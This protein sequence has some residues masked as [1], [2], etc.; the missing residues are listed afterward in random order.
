MG[1]Q[2]YMGMGSL[3]DSFD[4]P[5]G[6]G[7]VS[8]ETPHSNLA[9][10]YTPNYGATYSGLNSGIPPANGT[11]W[12]GLLMP[13]R[14]FQ[15][16]T[17]GSEHANSSFGFPSLNSTAF[18][19]GAN[20]TFSGLRPPTLN[21]TW[22][23]SQSTLPGHNPTSF[24]P[25]LSAAPVS[26]PTSVGGALTSQ[27]QSSSA[28]VHI[29]QS[30]AGV[31]TQSAPGSFSGTNHYSHAGPHRPPPNQS[32]R[33][34]VPALGHFG[35]DSRAFFNGQMQ[36]YPPSFV[37]NMIYSDPFF[38]RPLT[39]QEI[40]AN[41][42]IPKKLPIFSGKPTEWGNFIGFFYHT[43]KACRLDHIANSLRL[44]E[45]L[46]EDA[47]REVG[48]MLANPE[49]LP[50]ILDT[51]FFRFGRPEFIVTEVIDEIRSMEPLQEECRESFIRFATSVQRLNA[52][53]QGAGQTAQLCSPE[54]LQLLY[55]RMPL[56]LQNQW[57]EVI[58]VRGRVSVADLSEWLMRKAVGYTMMLKRPVLGQSSARLNVHV[59]A[60]EVKKKENSK[61]EKLK[62]DSNEQS[63]KTGAD[64]KCAYCSGSCKN[65]PTCEKFKRRSVD[66][67]WE[68]ARGR[69]LCFRCLEKGHPLRECKSGKPCEIGGCGKEHH[70]LLHYEKRKPKE[71]SKNDPK[72]GATIAVHQSNDNVFDSLYRIIP[73]VLYGPKGCV[74]TFAFLDDG[75][76]VTLLEDK[77]SEDLGLTGSR[78][79]LSLKWTDN[80]VKREPNSR[81]VS[82]EISGVGKFDSKFAIGDVR[83][84]QR[85]LLPEQTVDG[86]FIRSQ[87]PHLTSV[88]FEPYEKATPRI[89]IGL[90]HSFLSVPRELKEG[91]K[92]EPIAT[93]TRLGWVLQGGNSSNSYLMEV[94]E[95][96]SK[97][98][99]LNEVVQK[100][101]AHESLG[102]KIPE[103]LME[104]EEVVRSRKLLENGVK[105]LNTGFEAELLW[106][107]DSVELPN[108]YSNA[109][110]RL[111]GI[112]RRMRKD[113]R[114]KSA[115][116]EKIQYYIDQGFVRKLDPSEV[117]SE[118]PRRWFLP[119]F[120]VFNPNK[121][122]IRV[123]FD[124]AAVF[125]GHSLNSNLLVGP[126]FNNSLLKM[127]FK[128]RQGV[129][130]ISGD[131]K[132]MFLMVRV[133]TKDQPAQ[134][135]LWRDGD[136]SC[137]PQVYLVERLMFGETCA[138]AIAQFVRN[139]NAEHYEKQFPRAVQAI[140]NNHY[141]DDYLDS[142]DSSED[143][144]NIT[145]QVIQI[146]Q[147]ADFDI[148]NFI[149]NSPEVRKGLPQDA[150]H[151]EVLNLERSI[152]STE[153]VLGMGWLF[154]QDKFVFQLNFHRVKSD[155]LNGSRIPSKREVLSVLMSI[156]DPCGLLSNFTIRGKLI[157]QKT[158]GVGSDWDDPISSE[159]YED[160]KSWFA[161]VQKAKTLRIP[162]CYSPIA[163]SAQVELHTFVDAS[164]LAFAAVSY[165]RFSS[166]DKRIEVALV[167]AKTKV[168][169]K[170]VVSIPRLELQAAVLGS[171]WAQTVQ[172][173]HS[174]KI[175][176][177]VFWSDSLTVLN[178]IASNARKYKP[179]VAHRISE[180]LDGTNVNEWR[181][182]PTNENVADEATKVTNE[183]TLQENS[184][185]F[186][187]PS[188]LL[189][190]ESEWPENRQIVSPCSEELRSLHV[191]V[192]AKDKQL[193]DHSRFSN[194]WVLVR[195]I[196]LVVRGVR[197][198]LARVRNEAQFEGPYTAGELEVAEK[199]LFKQI[200]HEAYS[201]EIEAL[202]NGEEIPSN[203]PLF[204][205]SPY[206]EEGILR[207][208]GRIDASPYAS[209]DTKRPIILPKNHHV[210]VLLAL[211]YHRRFHHQVP[212]IV[213][214][215]LRKRFHISSVRVLVRSLKKHCGYC[216]V[217]GSKPN[218]PLMSPLPTQRLTPFVKPFLYTGVD[219]FGPY[220]VTIGRRSEERYGV[221]FTCLVMRAI[222]IEVANGTST[223]AFFL[224][225]RNFL[226]RRG[227]VAE[228]W[229]DNA[230]NFVGCDRVLN[231]SLK[232]YPANEEVAM[233][234]AKRKIAWHFITPAS[235]H[236]GGAWERLVGVVKNV[237][238]ILL[239]KR[240]LRPETLNSFLIEVE[241][242]VN[243]RPLTHVAVDR[244]TQDCL[245]PNHFLLGE[246]N[247]MLPPGRFDDSD[248]I[249]P[250][251]W[252]L[253]QM[254][255]DHFWRRWIEEYLPDLTRRTKW[256]KRAKPL[257]VGDLVFIIDSGEYRNTWKRG[258]IHSVKS[259]RDGQVRSAVVKL[260]N[261]RKLERP[262]TKLAA[263]DIEGGGQN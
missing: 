246:S 147:R 4:A 261:G 113:E 81:K 124:A 51:L 194:Y 129:V 184:R 28:G 160:W 75:S 103:R 126:D 23:P 90:R 57:A 43:T 155:I 98:R 141:M 145:R 18:N 173:G 254:L 102:V 167:G 149:S 186:R 218:P 138:P 21:I 136:S 140:Q 134:L 79:G 73:V 263:L 258:V 39:P 143:A 112:E 45:S 114:L 104:S 171:R 259:G 41:N 58:V 224:C 15:S 11:G 128:F 68:F 54:L 71:D 251:Q 164:E 165:F 212:N 99:E 154:D 208:A 179:F 217:A 76:G 168:A 115:Y 26:I 135:F 84:V 207:V 153:R 118:H 72:K 191:H 8:F 29:P 150:L 31:S 131:I 221:L 250:K 93:R 120:P 133:A 139:K 66:N 130:A 87:F 216:R 237:L 205:L 209:F 125:M 132:D 105:F 74:E 35:V 166:P 85:L 256:F 245:T 215:E 52:T 119:H 187:G 53:L 96:E 243:A 200:Q 174:L 227:R 195:T 255:A 101:F 111:E 158:F 62:G 249:G 117:P 14:S 211:S 2:N 183:P 42:S 203:S 192:E 159:L 202:K 201:C 244:D 235:P 56:S 226:N 49:N 9:P 94:C 32:I 228:I 161:T 24:P 231:R 197:N 7:D 19:A 64:K 204:K 188:F 20:R 148:R 34:P 25:P 70:A 238:H 219:L 151:G 38:W 260:A 177:R 169:P 253:S 33:H 83:T 40:L 176:R 225:L 170:K 210:T 60:K 242:I 91:L 230:T 181:W 223:E 152:E 80:V 127:I 178:W 189:N 108:N 36:N 12:S 163:T 46:M 97:Y 89:L 257:G 233:E 137:D 47:Q 213:I 44:K 162:R 107:A 63:P 92:E 247:G 106:R 22:Q 193:I 180:I 175:S 50:V 30:S 82:L 121:G 78:V 69:K 157:C 37:L 59:V 123:V 234:L 206:L 229:S 220:T 86:A 196:C 199:I 17:F 100:Y 144:L 27:P 156:F 146:H 198:A 214:N 190:E 61:P 241:N 222:H 239:E 65:L 172:D 252:R 88:P 122:K 10:G 95:C 110:K 182:V 248:E 13:N 16:L 55:D 5:D 1:S 109:L 6:F 232:D 48:W 185:W 236:H 3:N 77:I 142:F 262:A 116:I 240:S 67:R